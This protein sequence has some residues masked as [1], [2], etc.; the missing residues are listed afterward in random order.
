M[1]K[2]LK[3]ISEDGIK[4]LISIRAASVSNKIKSQSVVTLTDVLQSNLDSSLDINRIT[5]DS[6]P[7][8]PI[9]A[10]ADRVHQV[11]SEQQFRNFGVYFDFRQ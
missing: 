6:T 8:L 10:T 7:V 5:L 2:C 4:S 1:K 9:L 3:T 11:Q